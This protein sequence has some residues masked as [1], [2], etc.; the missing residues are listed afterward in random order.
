MKMTE[1]L[2]KAKAMGIKTEK[3]KKADLI[4]KIQTEEGN[5]PCF[6]MNG[7]ICDQAECCWRNDCLI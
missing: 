4:R 5:C 6:Q 3:L 1:V 2:K 7:G